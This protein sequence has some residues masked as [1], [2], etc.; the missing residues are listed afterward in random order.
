MKSN[1]NQLFLNF[2]AGREQSYEDIAGV[3][4]NFIYENAETGWKVAEVMPDDKKNSVKLCGY[5]PNVRVA[6]RICARCTRSVHPRFGM[7]FQIDEFYKEIPFQ[8]E[9]VIKFMISCIDGIGEKVAEKIVGKLK[10]DSLKIL[11][12]TPEKLLEIDGITENLVERIKK[13]AGK[14][15]TTVKELILIGF[16]PKWA[17]RIY[18]R[19]GSDAARMVREHPY[20]LIGDFKGIGFK[21]AEIIA[22]RAG[23]SK[24]DAERI[25]AGIFFSLNKTLERTG[26]NFLYLSELVNIS[27]RLL[28]IP[29]A[30]TESEVISQRRLVIENFRVYLPE[31]YEAEKAVA[32]IIAEKLFLP[33]EKI[34]NFSG[35]IGIIEKN[36]KL[37]FSDK[38]KEAIREAFENSVTVITGAAGTGKTTLCRGFVELL[39]KEGRTFKICAPTGK[40][41]YKLE[42]ITLVAASTI[43]RLFNYA[44]SVGF[45]VNSSHPLDCDYLIVDEASMVD[46]LLLRALLD[47]T[48]KKT[49]IVFIGDPYQ[50]PPVEAG[51]SLQAL[52]GS[53][54]VSQVY[55]PEIFRQKK[56]STILRNAGMVNLEKPFPAEST[57][58]FKFIDVSQPQDMIRALFDSIKDLKKQ[59]YHPIHDINILTPLNKGGGDI[60]VSNL[61]LRLRDYLN[62]ETADNSF[63][64]HDREFRTQDKVMQRKNDYD[65]DI[66]NG[67]IGFIVSNNSAASEVVIDF[68]GTEK[69]IPYS[70]MDNIT[71]NYA[72]TVHKAQGSESKAVIFLAT[73]AGCYFLLTKNLF[74][75][76]ITRAKEKLIM[77][78]P[79]EVVKIAVSTN[80]RRRSYLSER[81]RQLVIG[82]EKEKKGSGLEI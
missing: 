48:S 3:V 58:D 12:E 55:L 37:T 44:P 82:R 60:S 78:M 43:H 24:L 6:D 59:G 31:Y 34:K 51:N 33:V 27:S 40:A 70:K 76:A 49:R 14:I 42:A 17:G 72:M 35:K 67:D 50:L 53:Y 73:K 36:I 5:L 39:K 77:I 68:S 69:N 1:K 21:K 26:H 15:H 7:S 52:V 4:K 30:Y 62:P 79:Y 20:R 57:D 13:S 74:Y 10:G 54:S 2:I 28:E 32:N 64:I 45:R 23:V 41:A 61:N 56:Q 47:G 80:I 18:L 63:Y 22:Q 65:L 46:I 71:L 16:S 11:E 25:C 81:I 38:Q 66:Y 75:T 19:Y 29:R 9:G 8:K